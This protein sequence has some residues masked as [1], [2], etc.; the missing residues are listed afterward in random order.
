V[1]RYSPETMAAVLGDS[2]QLVETSTEEHAT[3][4]ETSQSFVYCRFKRV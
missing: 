3:P 1:V 2:F 4:R